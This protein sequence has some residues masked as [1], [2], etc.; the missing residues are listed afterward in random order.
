MSILA[1]AGL[2]N[3]GSRYRETRHN[4]G[5]SVVDALA[6]KG[7]AAWKKDRKHRAETARCD[8]GGRSIHMIKP[9]D[10]MNRSGQI[11]GP[12]CRYH[13]VAPERLAVVHDDI[14]LD[15]GRLKVSVGGGD[16]GH[17]GLAD[18]LRHLGNGFI[19]FR[20]GIGGKTHPEMDLADYVL[21]R[22]SD[23]ERKHMEERM[24]IYCE[25]LFSLVELGPTLT[26]NHF[27]QRKPQ[28]ERSNE[29][30]L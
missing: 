20:I 25:G 4:V 6:A 16:G 1:I 14:N 28:D 26:M 7:G 11:L 18:I 15:L 19:R 10:F 8:V 5:F 3:P 29:E 13:Q 23:E 24:P 27:N 30:N 22:F 12:W 21:S 2:G 9:M 17:N